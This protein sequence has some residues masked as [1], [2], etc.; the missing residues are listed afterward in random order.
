MK[1]RGERG[2]AKAA[3]ASLPSAP[4]ATPH[5]YRPMLVA[6]AAVLCI[7]W[8]SAPIS[9]SDFWWHL[10]TGQYVWEQHRLPVPDPFAFTTAGA[11][12]AY[13]AA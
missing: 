11:A 1:K 3:P 10:K 2:A 13:P 9:D 5:W 8:F 7:G 6:L 12:P 4:V